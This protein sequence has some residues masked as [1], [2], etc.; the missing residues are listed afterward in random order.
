MSVP[1]L[2]TL[3]KMAGRPQD[4]HDIEALKEIL[5]KGRA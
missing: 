2:I 5:K 4:L 3:K 1:D